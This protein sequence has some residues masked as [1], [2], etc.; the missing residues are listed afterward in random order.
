MKPPPRKRA[1]VDRSL[2]ERLVPRNLLSKWQLPEKKKLLK[3]LK[4]LG[5]TSGGNVDIDYASLKKSI[6]TRSVS[7]VRDNMLRR[8]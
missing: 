8:D 7:E 3:A 4:I 5:K 2:E 1:K 6:V